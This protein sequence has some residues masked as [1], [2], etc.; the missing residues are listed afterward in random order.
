MGLKVEIRLEPHPRELDPRQ[1]DELL[2]GELAEFEKW[3]AQRR[4]DR[5]R[6]AEPLMSIERAVLKAYMVYAATDRPK[7]KAA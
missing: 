4:Q 1:M 3:F 6:T 7:D 2:N 5:G